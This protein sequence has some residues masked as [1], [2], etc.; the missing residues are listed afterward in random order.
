MVSSLAILA[1]EHG[2]PQQHPTNGRVN[3]CSLVEGI[4]LVDTTLDQV[5]IGRPDLRAEPL[6]IDLR[7]TKRFDPNPPYYC[8]GLAVST[9]STQQFDSRGSP[10]KGVGSLPAI[11]APL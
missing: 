10:G 4:Y 5:N 11:S 3:L 7:E 1:T 6:V 9:C 2:N 8:P